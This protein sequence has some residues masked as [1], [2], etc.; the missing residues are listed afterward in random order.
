MHTHRE[1]DVFSGRRQDRG[2][3]IFAGRRFFRSVVDQGEGQFDHSRPLMILIQA[4]VYRTN[5]PCQRCSQRQQCTQLDC[6][7]R[8]RADLIVE[9]L[10]ALSVEHE[11][12]GL[13]RRVRAG[14]WQAQG[15][16]VC[17]AGSAFHGKRWV[18]QRHNDVAEAKQWVFRRGLCLV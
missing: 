15:Y 8:C 1:C 12:S 9:R 6:S 17:L 14:L 16:E 7:H 18:R 3:A 5:P 2:S 13:F 11:A 4:T 10:Q